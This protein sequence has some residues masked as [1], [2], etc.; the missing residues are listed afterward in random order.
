[1]PRNQVIRLVL[2]AV[3]VT[4]F[5]LT[6]VRGRQHGELRL[7]TLEGPIMGTSYTVRLVAEEL[8]AEARETVER[9]VQTAL[10]EVDQKMSTYRESSELSRFNRHR[11]TAPFPLSKETLEVVGLALEV[12]RE[13]GG[14]F[15]VTVAP[16]V[17]AWGFG[18]SRRRGTVP[19]DEELAELKARV[20]WQ[21]LELDLE[22]GALKKAIEGLEVD[23]SAVAKGY[24]VDRVAEALQRAG[25]HRFMVEVGGEVRTAG[26]NDAGTPW[27]IGIERPIPGARGID[28]VVRPGERALATSGSYKNFFDR[29]GER[30]SHTLDPRT[31]R[32]VT[33]R[34][35]SV[36]VLADTCALADAWATALEVLGPEEGWALVE[37]QGLAARFVVEREGEL[38]ERM[39]PSFARATDASPPG[40]PLAGDLSKGARR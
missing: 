4:A 31:A 27:R 30:L 8:S 25:R 16:L 23:L 14:A 22:R 15:D 3:L 1:M 39:T 2:L 34:L 13:S 9:A 26:T 24:A 37:R 6:V 19:S 20:G 35:V 7:Y 18:P 32:P 29:D 11:S 36:T 5:G 17:D 10:E 28:R 33:H 40:A 38:A 12:S 21:H